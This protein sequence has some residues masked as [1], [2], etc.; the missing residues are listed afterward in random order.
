M[1]NFT[2]KD[3][4]KIVRDMKIEQKN[5]FGFPT[6]IT[7]EIPENIIGLVNRTKNEQ[8]EKEDL[9]FLWSPEKSPFSYIYGLENIH[10][11]IPEFTYIRD[12]DLDEKIDFTAEAQAIWSVL[13]DEKPDFN[14][15][16]HW[17]RFARSSM[18]EWMPEIKL[19]VIDVD[20]HGIWGD[21]GPMMG[22]DCILHTLIHE[23]LHVQGFEH[24]SENDY[25][26]FTDMSNELTEKFWRK[27]E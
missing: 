16:L 2:E 22:P 10:V 15:E 6:I 18:G 17:N 8:K 20:K 23:F 19:I 24:K 25:Q 7:T 11:E 3:L 1:T 9:N 21:G 14:V 5:L 12:L 27:I 4:L 13:F 26:F